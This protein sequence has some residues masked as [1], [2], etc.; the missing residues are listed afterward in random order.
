MNMSLTSSDVLLWRYQWKCTSNK[1]WSTTLL[2]QYYQD[3]LSNNI[4]IEDGE[5][6]ISNFVSSGSVYLLQFYFS[7]TG[8]WCYFNDYNNYDNNYFTY[9]V[10]YISTLPTIPLN[11]WQIAKTEVADMTLVT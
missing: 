8:S 5:S 11:F 6:G 10:E 3:T 2:Y 7:H 1:V 9:K 4:I